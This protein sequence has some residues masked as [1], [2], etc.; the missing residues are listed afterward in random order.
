MVIH[1]HVFSR[2][3]SVDVVGQILWTF[4]FQHLPGGEQIVGIFHNI[5]AEQEQAD[6]FALVFAP[7]G[8]VG[9]SEQLKQGGRRLRIGGL[10]SMDIFKGDTVLDVDKVCLLVCTAALDVGLLQTGEIVL[11]NGHDVSF[12]L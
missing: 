6:C 2:V 10:Q 12:Q 3:D 8:A 5:R 4:A 7:V 11:G 9:E 1:G